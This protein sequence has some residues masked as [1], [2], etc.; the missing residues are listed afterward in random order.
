VQHTIHKP[1][2]LDKWP[3]GLPRTRL[4]L[5]VRHLAPELIERS[6]RAFMRPGVARGAG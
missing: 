1:V 4:V 3:D 2:H 5:I 6:F